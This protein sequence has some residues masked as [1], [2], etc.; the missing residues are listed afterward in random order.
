MELGDF[1]LGLAEG[2]RI[3]KRF[4]DGLAIDFP[5]KAE[6]R[7]VTRIVGPGAMAVGFTA[8]AGSGLDRPW[9]K[10]FEFQELS[11][12]GGTLG[13]KSGQ[14]KCHE[15]DLLS[16]YTYILRTALISCP[17]AKLSLTRNS[18]GELLISVD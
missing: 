13:F 3:G 15:G 5:Q 7:V 6:L 9:A 11:Q 17:V 4:R 18:Y 16:E 2:R 8:A 10:I 12:Q 1:P 14:G